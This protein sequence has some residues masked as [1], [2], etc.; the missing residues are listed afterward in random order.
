M[1]SKLSLLIFVVISAQI[2]HAQT[3][4]EFSNRVDLGVIEQ[5]ELV[6]A[7]GLVESRK[8]AHVLWSH[9]D[10]NHLN[11]LFAFNTAGKHLGIYWINGVDN[12][13][14]EDM[15]IG[16]GPQ[17][18]VDY[19]YIGDVGDNDSVHDFKYIYRVPEPVVDF[20]QE[21]VETTI[22]DVDTIIFQ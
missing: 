1:M 5:P 14:W 10:R 3:L 13:D 11:R 4:P 20:N 18:G 6:E 7:S 8:N 9:N 16:P 19:L 12:R 15:A 17:P 21:P 22:I 2:V